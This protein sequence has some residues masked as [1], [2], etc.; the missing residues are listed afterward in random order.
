MA[1]AIKEGEHIYWIDESTTGIV[2]SGT[3]TLERAGW[4]LASI[5]EINTGY[6]L[7]ARDKGTALL[8]LNDGPA[9]VD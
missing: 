6:Y 2:V 7:D 5:C 9:V 3:G 1:V 4:M 8:K